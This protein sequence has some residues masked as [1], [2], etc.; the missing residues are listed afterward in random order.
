MRNELLLPL[1]EVL[2]DDKIPQ[3]GFGLVNYNNEALASQSGRLAARLAVADA[4]PF[5]TPTGSIRVEARETGEPYVHLLDPYLTSQLQNGIVDVPVSIAHDGGIAVAVAGV[6][7]GEKDG[8]R[9]GIDITFADPEKRTFKNPTRK[10]LTAEEFEETGDDV[11]KIAAR[12]A[13]KEAVSK[14][15]GTGH[16]NGVFRQRIVTHEKDGQFFISLAESARPFQDFWGI[17]DWRISIGQE[18]SAII[19]LALGLT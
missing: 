15:L 8:F 3:L 5:R 19:A 1:C 10:L 16:T 4:L 2:V 12:W 11:N 7:R 13:I 18:G 17:E 14:T 6:N 9:V